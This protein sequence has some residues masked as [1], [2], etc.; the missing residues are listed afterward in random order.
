MALP[1]LISE[2]VMTINEPAIA[3]PDVAGTIRIDIEQVLGRLRTAAG[4]ETLD[5]YLVAC[6][7]VQFWA[8]ML[9]THQS[10]ESVAVTTKEEIESELRRAETEADRAAKALMGQAAAA[11]VMAEGPPLAC[12]ALRKDS[13]PPSLSKLLCLPMP[14]CCGYDLADLTLI[15]GDGARLTEQVGIGRPVL[16]VGIRTG[17]TYLA[18]LWKAALTCLGVADVHWCT[19]RPHAELEGFD[20]L[21]STRAWCKRKFKPVVVVVDDQPDTGTTMERVA[22]A[23]RASG[24]DLWFSSIGKL[25]RGPAQR[26]TRAR[27]PAP[28]VAHRSS[29]RLWECLLTNE[30]P[31]FIAR[32]QRTPGLPAL[33]D[34]AEL[35]FRCPQGEARYGT[36][37]VWLPW[38]DPQ[39]LNGQR[40]LVNPRKT[41]VAVCA[42]D[43]RALFHLRFVGDGVFGRAEFLRVQEIDSARRAWFIDGYTVT[44]DIGAARPF[45]EQFHSASTPARADLLAQAAHWL[46]ALTRHV[47]AQAYKSPVVMELGSRWSAMVSAM[48]ELCGSSLDLPESLRAFL[49]RP[50]PWLGRSSKAIR[51]S[52]RYAC[53]GWHW[54]VDAQGRLHRFQLEANW[55]DVSF[56]ELELAAFALENR[57]SLADAQHLADLCGLAYSSIHESLSLAAL[58]IAEARMRSVRTLSDNGRDALYQDFCELLMTTSELAAFET[59]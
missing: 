48:Q 28:V 3:H 47:V 38:N 51:T 34:S 40:P 7:A 20:G 42:R 32:L 14:E 56:P 13:R 59:L 1:H 52:T 2:R 10:R 50:L 5:R 19:V 4:Q 33:P 43:G 26:S 55:G 22:A 37:R 24:V 16:I 46:T 49:A 21:V 18:P 8:D 53:G 39:V 6:A 35:Q 29:P 25:W 27:S 31:R 44:V 36:G 58:T 57:L 12:I 45:R 11:P 15:A 41:P 30:H 54:Q 23:L 17:G 9:A